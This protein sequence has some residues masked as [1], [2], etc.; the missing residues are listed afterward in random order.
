MFGEIVDVATSRMVMLQRNFGGAVTAMSGKASEI[1]ISSVRCKGCGIC[2]EFC[3]A[4]VLAMKD[5]KSSVV[6]LDNC[7]ACNLC[8]LRCPDF[9]IK[10]VPINKDKAVGAG[11]S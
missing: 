9:A 5:G 2:V 7:T 6:A 1:Q 11:G 3:P 8:D 10:V 4:G